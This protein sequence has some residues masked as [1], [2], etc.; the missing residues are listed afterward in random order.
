[1]ILVIYD[2]LNDSAVGDRKY[3]LDALNK[4]NYYFDD[5]RVIDVE[6]L[7][8]SMLGDISYSYFY[9]NEFARHIIEHYP[10]VIYNR[11][12][13]KYTVFKDSKLITNV[14]SSYDFINDKIVKD[15]VDSS[16]KEPLVI[17]PIVV[18][19]R[20]NYLKDIFKSEYILTCKIDCIT[21]GKLVIAEFNNNL[22]KYFNKKLDV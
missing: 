19:D 7:F 6:E 12:L 17:H 22:L 2:K 1:M 14:S 10:E 5:S 20:Y 11:I 8:R 18:I 9:F 13:E 4:Q 21:N 15:K 3:I 16:Y